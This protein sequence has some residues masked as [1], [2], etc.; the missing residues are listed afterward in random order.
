MLEQMLQSM[1]FYF[2]DLTG[3]L[4]PDDPLTRVERK[5]A[6]LEQ[7]VRQ[8]LRRLVAYRRQVE[9]LRE[10]AER[11]ERSVARLS[12]AGLSAEV[13]ELSERLSR[14]R[15]LLAGR[16]HRYE[17]CLATTKRLQRKLAG[18]ASRVPSGTG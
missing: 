8:R 18:M 9:R 10:R 2:P 16:L 14:D 4:F 17:T 11:N 12:G 7:A 6:R 5:R 15:V 1:R 13:Q 3:E